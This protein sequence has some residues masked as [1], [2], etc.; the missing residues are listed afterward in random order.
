MCD[1]A[2]RKSTASRAGGGTVCAYEW[3][4]LKTINKPKTSMNRRYDGR[5]TSIPPN[6]RKSTT[7]VWTP[8]AGKTGPRP[9]VRNRALRAL[10]LQ[11]GCG[12]GDLH[13]TA[14]FQESS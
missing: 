6:P 4:R 5:F 13:D 14:F 1:G 10:L 7:P 9:E 11:F 3:L 8:Q 12:Y 2:S